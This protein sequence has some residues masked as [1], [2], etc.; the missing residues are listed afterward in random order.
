[1]AAMVFAEHLRRA[2][3]DGRVRVTSAGIGGWHEGDPADAR[4]VRVLFEHDYPTEH[5]AAQVNDDHLS[6][7]LLVA[8]DNGHDRDLRDLLA[9]QG[10]TADHLRMFRSFDPAATGLIDV[11]D[12]YFGDYDGF[13]EVLGLVE[14]AMPG[15]L[16][17]VRDN[18]E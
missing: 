9:R 15:L 11:P 12:P 2:G 7:D 8:M 3:L 6:A 13:L 14:A 18:L 1:M 10:V 5:S 17:W 4:T 16:E